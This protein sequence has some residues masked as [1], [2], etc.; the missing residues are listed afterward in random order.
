MLFRAR[1]SLSDVNLAVAPQLTNTKR[2]PNLVCIVILGPFSM[3]GWKPAVHPVSPQHGASDARKPPGSRMRS[4]GRLCGS[5]KLY[6][7]EFEISFYIFFSSL[8]G[9][10]PSSALPPPPSLKQTDTDVTNRTLSPAL[11]EITAAPLRLHPLACSRL[12]AGGA[13]EENGS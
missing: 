12:Q 3:I 1:G 4:A 9:G 13:S 11:I 6:S 5:L 2:K 10:E 8:K 7:S